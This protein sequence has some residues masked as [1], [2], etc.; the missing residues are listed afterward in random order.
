[1]AECSVPVVCGDGEAA[2]P[3]PQDNLGPAEE[4]ARLANTEGGLRTEDWDGL[5][6]LAFESRLA[7]V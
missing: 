4:A 1:M 7:R 5:F 3:W 6:R 2:P